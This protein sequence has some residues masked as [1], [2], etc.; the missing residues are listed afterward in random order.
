MALVY[1]IPVPLSEDAAATIPAA[2][3][4]SIQQCKVFFAENIRTARR[5]FKKINPSIVIDDYEWISFS[6]GDEQAKKIFSEKL[7]AGDAIGIV[8]EA[9]CPGIADPG[10]E[11]VAIAHQK[12]A[13]VKPFVGPSS[14]LLALMASGL[15]GQQFCFHG[16]LPIEANER[17]KKIKELESQ[18]KRNG[19]TQ[20]FIETPYRNNQLLDA[21]LLHTQ[22]STLL[23]IA[24]DLTATTEFVYTR[25]ISEWK[26]EKPDLHKRPVIFCL[27]G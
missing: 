18:S 15:N 12:G 20:I 3:S 16:Y 27:R 19:S 17:A 22:P 6:N 24:A 26:K 2:V 7:K 21:I 4:E 23:C 1:L 8:S 13:I 10:Q 14:I 5:F 9:G 11:L 25:S